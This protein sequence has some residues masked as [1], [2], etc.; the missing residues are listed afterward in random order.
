MKTIP[1]LPVELALVLLLAACGSS[2]RSVVTVQDATTITKGQELV[3]LQR[4]LNEGAL[5][6]SE[7]ER[8][9]KVIMDRPR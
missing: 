4:A 1:R 5:T 3:D 9:R 2:S 6:Q 7:Y 8:V